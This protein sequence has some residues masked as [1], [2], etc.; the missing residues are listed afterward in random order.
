MVCTSRAHLTAL[1]SDHQV[2]QASQVP[3]AAP[4]TEA[5][6]NKQSFHCKGKSREALPQVAPQQT[7]AELMC[8]M[9]QDDEPLSVDGWVPPSLSSLSP[10]A[11][12]LHTTPPTAAAAMQPDASHNLLA[13]AKAQ[14]SQVHLLTSWKVVRH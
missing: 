5:R 2:T 11:S 3:A 13:K 9:R 12:Q 1:A 6:A 4:A 7:H 10:S 8:Q 14:P